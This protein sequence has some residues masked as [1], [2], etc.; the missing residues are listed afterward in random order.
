MISLSNTL[1]GGFNM[2]DITKLVG[3]ILEIACG[4]LIVFVIPYIKSKVNAQVYNNALIII[5]MAVAAAEQIFA[6]SG[7][8][9]EKKAYVLNYL[10]EHNIKLDE[11]ALDAAIEAS[12]YRLRQ[13]AAAD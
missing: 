5:D 8:G 11:K 13:A 6:G 2:I 9:Q 10:A 3:A 1:F 4:L 7:R 12:V